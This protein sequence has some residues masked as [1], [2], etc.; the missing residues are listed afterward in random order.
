MVSLIEKLYDDLKAFKR[1]LTADNNPR[2]AKHHLRLR[3]EQL[4]Q[5]WFDEVLP[6]LDNM[7]LASEE[8]IEKYST[9][10]ERLIRLSAPNNHKKSYLETIDNLVRPMRDELIV[11]AKA[12]RPMSQSQTLFETFV[13]SLKDPEESDYFQEAINCAN[14]GFLRAA[15]VLA[16]CAAI[17]RVHRKIEQIGFMKFS[18]ISAQMAS[19]PKGRFRRFNSPQNVTSLSELRKVFDSN[20]LWIVEGM[21]LI[22]SN[23]H[24]RLRSCF[25]MRCQCAHPGEAPITEYNLMSMFSDIQQIILEN[26]TFAL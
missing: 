16:W 23:Q 12:H 2:V 15:A 6:E 9:A 5:F 22:D 26:S 25:E 24:T 14:N 13:A 10:C 7:S 4:G 20:I 11:P 18:V 21:G 17:D 19:Q 8:T 1:E 3:A